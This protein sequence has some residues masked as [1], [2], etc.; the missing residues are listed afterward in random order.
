MII[1][2]LAIEHFVV[3]TPRGPKKN[4]RIIYL[5]PFSILLVYASAKDF[6][7]LCRKYREHLE[8]IDYESYGLKGKIEEAET[9]FNKIAA[10][11]ARHRCNKGET[12]L[13]HLL[14]DM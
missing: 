2:V 6:A 5:T 11:R 14:V 9:G 8:Q 12:V 7:G 4:C 1:N 10:F 3:T 13:Y